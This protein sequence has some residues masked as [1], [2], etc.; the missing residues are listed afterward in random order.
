MSSCG[1]HPCT[2]ALQMQKL[3]TD[4][5][6]CLMPGQRVIPH[7]WLALSS[8]GM[9]LCQICWAWWRISYWC[10]QRWYKLGPFHILLF[11]M[12]LSKYSCLDSFWT[13]VIIFFDLKKIFAPSKCDL[14][15]HCQQTSKILHWIHTAQ[16][17][18]HHRDTLSFWCIIHLF[19]LPCRHC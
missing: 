14:F 19:L 6:H 18:I 17:T 16:L 11:D 12:Y 15:Q 10:L 4:F 8:S 3:G 5:G 9:H 1:R 7:G 2:E 13:D